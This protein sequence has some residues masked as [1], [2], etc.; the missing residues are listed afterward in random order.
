[1]IQQSFNF[2]TQ[3]AISSRDHSKLL[4]IK[5]PLTP[6]MLLKE[7]YISQVFFYFAKK[8]LRFYDA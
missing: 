8:I 6:K 7:V 4:A 5:T 3:L 1:M 2:K